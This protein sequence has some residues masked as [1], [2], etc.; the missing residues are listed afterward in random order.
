MSTKQTK[1]SEMDVRERLKASPPQNKFLL[2]YS[3]IYEAEY[4]FNSVT[5]RDEVQKA[6]AKEKMDKVLNQCSIDNLYQAMGFEDSEKCKKALITSI[7]FNVDD[8]GYI[9]IK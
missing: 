4:R 5:Y 2:L 7:R 6:E 9:T 8:N 3:I 1:V